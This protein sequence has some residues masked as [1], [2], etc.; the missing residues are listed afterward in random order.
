MVKNLS[1]D[2]PTSEVDILDDVM[3]RVPDSLE[4]TVIVKR[5]NEGPRQMGQR[6]KKRGEANP[7]ACREV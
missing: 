7:Y 6:V 1:N 3:G 5:A 2:Y 4:Q